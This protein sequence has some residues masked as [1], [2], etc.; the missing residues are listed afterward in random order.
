MKFGTCLILGDNLEITERRV[1]ILHDNGFKYCQPQ[2]WEP[3]LWTDEYADQLKALFEKY[4]ITPTSFWCGWEGPKV[5]DFYDGPLTLGLVPPEYRAVR[6]KN[7]CDGADFAKKMG[8]T[9]VVTHM[10]FIP[11]TP[12]D[13]NFAPFCAAVRYVAEHLKKN[14]QWLLFETGQETPVTLLRTIEKV[15]MDNL[16]INLDT[17]NVMS[18]GRGNP[19]DA[20][21]VFGKYVRNLHAKDTLLPA[22]GH[23]LGVETPIGKGVVPFRAIIEKLHELNY[24]AHITIEREI[25]GDQQMVDILES[26]RFLEGLLREIYGDDIAII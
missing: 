21:C 10:G 1:K 23:D 17:A 3:W 8:I 14:D 16:G 15:D 22:N 2:S 26:R 4:D 5:W 11:E 18:Y 6:I 25:E 12:Y 20:L 13:P 19:Y 9:D 7:L 24:D